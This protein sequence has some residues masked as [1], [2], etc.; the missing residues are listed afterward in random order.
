MTRF[1]YAILLMLMPFASYA[2]EVKEPPPP[3]DM[4]SAILFIILFVGSIVGFSVY[5]WYK[6][7]DASET[8]KGDK[9]KVR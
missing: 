5:M 1:L 4:T 6:K 3:T 7:E 2:D 9:K 8:E